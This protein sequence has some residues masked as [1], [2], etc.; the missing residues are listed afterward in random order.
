MSDAWPRASRAAPLPRANRPVA[1][2]THPGPVRVTAQRRYVTNGSGPAAEDAWSG[3]RCRGGREPPGQGSAPSSYTNLA[4]D[5]DGQDG[6][7]RSELKTGA[8]TCG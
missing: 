6:K 3:G 2:A 1:M 8:Q 7:S 4:L 5:H